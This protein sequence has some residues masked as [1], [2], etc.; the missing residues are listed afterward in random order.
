MIYY[1]IICMMYAR[2]RLIKKNVILVLE[3]SNALNYTPIQNYYLKPW[4]LTIIGFHIN[5][6]ELSVCKC[7]LVSYM[8]SYESI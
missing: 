2:N 1:I 8:C 6:L 4:I 5:S 3:V 7:S